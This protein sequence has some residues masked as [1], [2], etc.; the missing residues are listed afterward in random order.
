MVLALTSTVR[1][2]ADSSAQSIPP[3]SLIVIGTPMGAF[4]EVVLDTQGSRNL[5]LRFGE[6]HWEETRNITGEYS[7][8]R[9]YR[10]LTNPFA[11]VLIPIH[12]EDGKIISHYEARVAAYTTQDSNGRQY[13]IS[14]DGRVLGIGQHINR[15][16]L[17]MEGVSKSLSENI[18][19]RNG[20]TVQ[21]AIK[22]H[23]LM[24]R[25]NGFESVVDENIRIDRSK[26]LNI[27]DFAKA[28]A[29]AD[30]S[31]DAKARPADKRTERVERAAR[32][33]G[34]R[35]RAEDAV[36]KGRDAR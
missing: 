12:T 1:A 34:E 10:P 28:L 29:Q 32:G 25:E 17:A 19:V 2:A 36:R 26:E 5:T 23:N 21:E 16:V 4:S 24:A 14:G 33:A 22:A 20:Q 18:A 27:V 15:D 31:E 11:L 6:G 7:S 35:A 9:V 13:I 8:A 30:A 3:G